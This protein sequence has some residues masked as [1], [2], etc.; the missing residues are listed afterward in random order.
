MR[1]VS[2]WPPLPSPRLTP[3][4]PTAVPQP[5]PPPQPHG[6]SSQRSTFDASRLCALH[7]GLQPALLQCRQMQCRCRPHGSPTARPAVLLKYPSRIRA[8]PHV[9]LHGTTTRMI[10][11]SRTLQAWSSPPSTTLPPTTQSGPYS[12]SSQ[13]SPQYDGALH[14]MLAMRPKQSAPAVTHASAA[15]CQGYS[16][17]TA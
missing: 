2:N 16:A 1:L 15:S 4:P 3:S 8:V 9:S 14:V 11:G 13:L 10:P 6:T 7:R 5:Y 17:P 12:N